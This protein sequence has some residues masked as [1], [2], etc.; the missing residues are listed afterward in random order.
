M[1]PDSDKAEE[2]TEAEE[3]TQQEEEDQEAD[4]LACSQKKKTGGSELSKASLLSLLS[5]MSHDTL[6]YVLAVA[7]SMLVGLCKVSTSNAIGVAFDAISTG[8]P[9][10]PAML[11]LV[12]LYL[13]MAILTFVS[14]STQSIAIDNL[15]LRLK[16]ALFEA[17]L[18]KDMEYFER[19]HGGDGES[20]SASSA[21]AALGMRMDHDVQQAT[22]AIRHLLSS[23][24]QSIFT[25]AGGCVSMAMSSGQLSG[26]MMLSTPLAAMLFTSFARYIKS[27]SKRIRGKIESA[28]SSLAC[29]I[30]SIETVQSFAREG[31]FIEQFRS[32]MQA[33]SDM[34]V[35]LSLLHGMHSS[36]VPTAAPLSLITLHLD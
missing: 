5:A 9:I 33:S 26:F 16:V 15:S 28:T 1:N 10:T 20:D 13:G 8:D 24:V 12:A 14:A 18:M 22:R 17:A 31:S 35:R 21:S 4:M 2:T 23:G 25:I 30:Q 6:L 7:S 27:I 34:K 36:M 32:D 29:A 19:N 3:E 11:K